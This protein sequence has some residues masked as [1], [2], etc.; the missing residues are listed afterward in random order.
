G[1]LL[2]LAAAQPHLADELL[3]SGRAVGLAFD[4][5]QDGLVGNHVESDRGFRITESNRG[6]TRINTDLMKKK[7]MGQGRCL[8]IAIHN[9]CSSASIRG[10]FY[11]RSRNLYQRPLH[12]TQT[13][14]SRRVFPD[15]R[16][17]CMVTIIT[18]QP[19]AH[20][21]RCTKGRTKPTSEEELELGLARVVPLQV[22]FTLERNLFTDMWKPTN[23]P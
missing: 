18:S 17:R 3:E 8:Q 7:T 6:F 23:A 11:L 21:G 12:S 15:S 19:R 10:C 14:N 16:T 4:A 9:P 1:E 22:R 20:T 13:K 5:T 2:P